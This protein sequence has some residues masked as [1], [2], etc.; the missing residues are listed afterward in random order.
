ML[1]AQFPNQ[2]SLRSFR[3]VF[4][5]TKESNFWIVSLKVILKGIK[6]LLFIL[7]F[8]AILNVFMTGGE[9]APLVEF[10]IIRIYTE[11]IVRAVFMA[12]RVVLLIVI[13]SMLLTYTTS[14]ISLTDGLESLLSPLKLIRIPVHTFGMMMSIALR[15]IP[16]LVEET[17]KIMNAQKSRGAD[18]SSQSR[19]TEP[20]S[21]LNSN[22]HHNRRHLTC[23]KNFR[24]F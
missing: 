11:G 14:P 7:L 9:G 2:I 19:Q 15:F 13:T 4:F 6:P 17:E 12:L 10:W 20:F 1:S 16:T 8:T 24:D 22:N 3:K 5:M 23:P 18:F 21:T